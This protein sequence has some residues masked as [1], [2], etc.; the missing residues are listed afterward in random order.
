MNCERISFAPMSFL[1]IKST[2]AIVHS[3]YDMEGAFSNFALY[4]H[5]SE[6][7]RYFKIVIVQYY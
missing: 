2:D 6:S 7:H 3:S 5:S 4:E 1:P